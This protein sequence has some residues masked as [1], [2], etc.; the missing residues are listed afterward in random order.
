MST[1]QNV[2]VN[3]R[4]QYRQRG[5]HA[6]SDDEL[7]RKLASGR[8]LASE[9]KRGTAERGVNPSIV[10]AAAAA[11]ADTLNRAVAALTR[12]YRAPE[13]RVAALARQPGDA[14]AGVQPGQRARRGAGRVPQPDHH[15]AVRQVRAAA[16]RQAR[17]QHRGAAGHEP[18]QP[19]PARRGA[20][21]TCCTPRSATTRRTW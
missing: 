4:D 6:G 21:S 2:I 8:E 9:L 16:G 17:Q 7:L 20:A 18:D 19:G 12:A 3:I 13:H 11:D 10:I 15:R 14:V 1:S 5:R